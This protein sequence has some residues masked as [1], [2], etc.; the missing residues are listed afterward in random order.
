MINSDDLLLSVGPNGAGKS[1][2]IKLLTGE[3]LPDS[4]R[5]EKHP[6]LRVAYVAQHAFHH[7][8]VCLFFDTKSSSTKYLL[9]FRNTWRRPPPNTFNGVTKMVTTRSSL[10]RLLELSLLRRR[11]CSIPPSLPVRESREGSR[12]SSDD[13]SKRRVTL[14]RLNGRT[15]IIELVLVSFLAFSKLSTKFGV[16]T[17]VQSLPSPRASYGTRFPEARSRVR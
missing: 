2:L 17:S 3:T 9:L 7:I 12:G 5:V 14:M 13:R 15:W 6:N 4:G 11:S 10:P 1:T 16:S 8:E